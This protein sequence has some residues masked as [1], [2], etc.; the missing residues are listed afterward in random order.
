MS[1]RCRE[2]GFLIWGRDTKVSQSLSQITHLRSK[3][4]LDAPLKRPIDEDPPPI[5]NMISI[6]KDNTSSQLRSQFSGELQTSLLET[7]SQHS[8]TQLEPTTIRTTATTVYTPTSTAIHQTT[9]TCL[10]TGTYSVGY[11][12]VLLYPY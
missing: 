9:T 7:V 10:S 8:V 12:S 11:L 5:I 3:P 1:G 2:A 4:T 6:K